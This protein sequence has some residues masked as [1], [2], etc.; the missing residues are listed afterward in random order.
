MTFVPFMNIWI[1][2]RMFAC[3]SGYDDHRTLDTPAKVISGIIGGLLGLGILANIL[4]V[5]LQS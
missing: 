2:W 3:P 1:T 4:G 5:V